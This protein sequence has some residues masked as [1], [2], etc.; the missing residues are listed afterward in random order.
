MQ[1]TPEHRRIRT[2]AIR[3]R[4]AQ[5]TLAWRFPL[6]QNVRNTYST[7]IAQL[8]FQQIN[9]SPIHGGFSDG[10][11]WDA[12]WPLLVAHHV[13]IPDHP[14]HGRSLEIK[15]LE[16]NDATRR[17]ASL[18]EAKAQKL[19]AHVV[20]ISIGA[21]VAA[22]MAA[23]YPER[24]QTLIVSGFNL[25]A[26]NLVSPILP[27]LVYAAQRG[28]G[29]LS[30]TCDIFNILFSSR[31]LEPITARSLVVA[32]TRGISADNVSHSRRLFETVMD[33]GSRLVQHRG[34]RHPWNADEPQLFANMVMSWIMGEDL[35]DGFESIP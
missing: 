1:Q 33:N 15:P 32:A 4:P 35:P 28:R 2:R 34:M 21:H 30:T 16:I 27:Y 8:I 10:Q 12:V 3:P 6:H 7:Y 22:A 17:L 9:D 24:V 29:Y 11:E 18:I 26:S 13:L 5:R 14:A 19:I 31:D 20:A 25:F 23:Q